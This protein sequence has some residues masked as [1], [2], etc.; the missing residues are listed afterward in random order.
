M[1]KSEPAISKK[2]LFY[3]SGNRR[4]WPQR[5]LLHDHLDGCIAIMP[6][7]SSLFQMS[8]KKYPFRGAPEEQYTQVKKLFSNAQ[9]NI[10]EKFS[11]TTGVMQ[12]RETLALAAETYVRVRARQGFAI[13]EAIVAPQYHTFGG[14]SVPEVV[15]ALIA[16]IK[17][18]E[19]KYPAIEV[20]LI[21]AVGR[22]V[23]P[24][25]AVRL[26][27]QAALC[28]RNYVVG[29]G[30]ACDEAGYPP[31]KHIAMFE[32]AK[33]FGFKTTVHAGELVS[34]K[35]D[36][37]RDKE[38]LLK[39]I[40]TAIFDLKVDRLGHAIPLAQDEGLLY[41]VASRNIAVEGCPGSNLASGL[42][43]N[44]RYLGIDKLLARNIRYSLNP[45]DDLFLP[46]LDETF[47]LCD[48]E[49][50]F[51]EEQ[52]MHLRMN[53]WSSAFS[54]RKDHLPQK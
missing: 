26:V 53:A 45:D 24:G 20:N 19:E 22:E 7:L 33:D 12:T 9:I 46:N 28:D 14:L 51:S 38:A 8:G 4:I 36:Y 41:E 32:C 27:N 23:D 44:T 25:E 15:A 18:G 17:R 16:G 11:N 39:N 35:P 31:E 40:R 47:E 10:V 3:F 52:K 2:S 49:Y 34:T 43:P 29:I 30:L 1:A 21:F 13:C 48:K 54:A 6:A 42:I 37:K 5:V 50:H